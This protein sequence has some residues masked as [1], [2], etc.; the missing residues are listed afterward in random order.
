MSIATSDGP[1]HAEVA[2]SASRCNGGEFVLHTAQ[3]SQ[4]QLDVLGGN[5]IPMMPDHPRI[6]MGYSGSTRT[7]VDRPTSVIADGWGAAGSI[8]A[9]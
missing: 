9:S 3:A 5:H 2:R 1:E 6:E 7:S 4:G 8:G